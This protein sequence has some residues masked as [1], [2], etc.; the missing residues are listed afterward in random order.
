MVFDTA[1]DSTLKL[2]LTG[3]FFTDPTTPVRGTLAN[4]GVVTIW[5]TFA[6]TLTWGRFT[7]SSYKEKIG[8]SLFT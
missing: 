7:W 1:R 8:Q 6:T 3:D 2:I 4:I 5:K